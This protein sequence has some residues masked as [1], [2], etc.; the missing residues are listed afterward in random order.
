MSSMRN[1][2]A[3]VR[4]H[5]LDTLSQIPRF[6]GRD[7]FGTWLAKIVNRGASPIALA[8]LDCGSKVY[9][10]LR[11]PDHWNAYILHTYD[12]ALVSS[13]KDVLVKPGCVFMD[14]GASV[15]L[16]SMGLA[17][18][19]ESLGGCV[20]AYE[21]HEGNRSLLLKSVAENGLS[22]RMAVYPFALGSRSGYVSLETSEATADVGNAM[23][24]GEAAAVP[25]GESDSKMITLDEHVATIGLER[26]DCIKLDVEG[27][28]FEVLR[29]AQDT[30]QR[31]KPVIFG[32]FNTVFLNQRGVD[33]DEAWACLEA[34]PY[35]LAQF[36]DGAWK[37]VQS[38]PEQRCWNLR[39]SPVL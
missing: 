20:L 34:M 4:D 31:L 19:V 3:R 12:S 21:P 35:E 24:V 1:T 7:R 9:V 38:R 36:C 30:L 39:M 25:E 29:G 18:H 15:G 22:G 8:R 13:L 14:I 28:E 5:V 16:I 23:I 37:P 10:D 2:R 11:C 32:E 27:F 17:P 26:L 6:K 33:L